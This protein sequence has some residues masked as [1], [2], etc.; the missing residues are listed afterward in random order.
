MIHDWP[1]TINATMDTR[2]KGSWHN[3]F[4]LS[5]PCKEY[6]LKDTA[7]ARIKELEAAIR[8]VIEAAYPT[9]IKK[10]FNA[11][12]IYSK[13]D[14]CLHNLPRY[15]GCDACVADYLLKVLAP[16]EEK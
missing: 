10:H 16:T 14:I 12:K 15:N 5:V 13:H 11:D 4:L 9:V 6:I 7:G 2:I 1:E 8:V 3:E